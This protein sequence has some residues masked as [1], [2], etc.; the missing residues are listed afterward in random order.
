MPDDIFAVPRLARVYDELDGPRDD[1]V[2]YHAIVDELG[3]R[4]VLDI[5]CGTGTFSCELARRSLTVTA[6][7]PAA[8][9]LAV[10]R[11]K[12]GAELVQW[13]HA[14]ATAIPELRV[15]VATMTGNV[16]Q[17]FVDDDE[18]A[19]VLGSVRGA[20]R[21]GGCFVFETREPAAKAWLRWTKEATL[22]VHDTL[23]EGRV[24]SWTELTDVTL[25]L[26][27]FRHHYLFER[28]GALLSSD[29]TL[30][31]RSRAEIEGSLADGGF[32]V[33]DVRGA[34]DRPGLENV[35]IAAPKF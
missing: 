32:E 3:A 30:R 35:F 17:V 10:A 2:H 16:A 27:S 21:P 6:L 26:V 13:I 7:D 4:S 12:V 25:P 1:L 34:P 29:S 20:L 8:A 24:Q 5:G 22:S 14:E 18:W 15:D 11:G 23:I 33:V 31:F 9:S 28:D 19:Q